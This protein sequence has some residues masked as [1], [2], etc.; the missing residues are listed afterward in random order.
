MTDKRSLEYAALLGEEFIKLSPF[1][2]E[3]AIAHVS[4]NDYVHPSRFQV[5][6]DHKPYWCKLLFHRGFKDFEEDIAA[7]K[8]GN[9]VFLVKLYQSLIENA[10]FPPGSLVA[11]FKD[12]PGLNI[13][14]LKPE[15]RILCQAELHH[16]YNTMQDFTRTQ[17]F[18]FDML[19]SY[20]IGDDERHSDTELV[21]NYG[22]LDDMIYLSDMQV[23]R[24][25]LLADAS[26][27]FY[28]N[29]PYSLR[30]N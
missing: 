24:T 18:V 25:E 8:K 12:R 23:I 28:L 11:S 3:Y 2:L 17:R 7:A 30:K 13:A 9:I 5:I 26:R 20:G 29:T 27:L 14:L 10:V 21:Y 19:K 15:M 4:N 6:K 1:A 16:D 22:T